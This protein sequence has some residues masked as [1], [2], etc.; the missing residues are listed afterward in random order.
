[1]GDAADHCNDMDLSDGLND[2]ASR[3]F[4]GVSPHF[5]PH[6]STSKFKATHEANKAVKVGQKINCPVCRKGF[7]KRSYQ[8][9]FCSNRG[10]GNCKDEYWNNVH[11]ERMERVIG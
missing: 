3:R 4:W 8:H 9:S 5:E 7:K 11:P 2:P 6:P 1:M 10:R